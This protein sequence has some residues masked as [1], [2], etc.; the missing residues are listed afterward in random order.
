MDTISRES[1]SSYLPVAGV[2]VGVLALILGVVAL[3]KVSSLSKRVPEDLPDKLSSLDTDTRNAAAAADRAAKGIASLQ[4]STQSALDQIGPEV[5]ALR[6]T[7]KKLDDAAKAH[8]A[9]PRP[10]HTATGGPAAATAAGA[11]EYV[12]QPGDIGTKIARETGL[13]IE[14]LEALNPG[15]NWK[16]LKPGQKLKTK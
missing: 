3:A 5:A 12:V 15:I 1:N 10:P 13:S 2:L 11:G 16:L 6:D 4:S 14:Q 8:A 9:A 7:V